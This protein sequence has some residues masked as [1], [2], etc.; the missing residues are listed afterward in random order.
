MLKEVEGLG[1][2]EISKCL[3]LSNSNVKVRLHRAR[4]MLK[5]SI[6]DLT[7]YKNIFEFGNSK[8][9]KVVANVMEYIYKIHA[10]I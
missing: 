2:S 1:I 4:T 8:C 5:N 3:N 7:D 9:D 10:T 6:L